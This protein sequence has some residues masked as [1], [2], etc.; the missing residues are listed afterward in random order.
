MANPIRIIHFSDIHFTPRQ[1]FIRS[2]YDAAVQVINT[3][4]H[5]FSVFTGDLTQDGLI[6]EYVLANELRR[7]II[8]PKTY[9]IIG[10]HD[11]RSGGFEVWE[12][13]IG[14]REFHEFSDDVLFIGLD[15]CIPDRDGGRFGREALDYTKK[16][17]MKYGD[18]KIKIVG[19]HHHI[20]PIPKT[21]R[22][23]SNAID[24][25]DMLSVL[26]DHNIDVVFTGHKH[27][28]NVYKVEDTII[29]SAGCV[30]SY[31][32]RS[33]GPRSLN[34]VEII[35]EKEVKTKIMETTGKMMRQEVKTITRSFRM[36]SSDGGK[37]LRLAQISGT[38]FG[39]SYDK[40]DELFT[41]GMELIDNTNPD[42]ILH[43]GNL[44]S[45]GS[46]SDYET[47]VEKFSKYS[48][49]FVFCPGPN[50]LKGY[51]ET[52][53]HKHFDTEN[54]FEKDESC[55][56]ILNTSAPETQV[57][58]VGRTVQNRLERYVYYTRQE[59]LE[60][61][62]TVV[63]H[64]H[65][66]PIPGTRETSA[67]EDA[68]DVLRLLT[69][70][71]VNLVLSGHLGKAFCTRVEKTAFVNCNTFASQTT[72]SFENSFNLIDISTDGAI[73]VSEIHVPSGFRRI[74]GIFPGLLPDKY[75]KSYV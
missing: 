27:H 37:W 10:N 16:I 13:K 65:L 67:L 36:V 34:Y 44:T 40:H 18:A 61:F 48:D 5:D 29:V 33:G 59:N 23:R 1:Q 26:L 24:A 47:A 62:H 31:K 30:S 12:K 14:P 43:C 3:T 74:L 15:S 32:T 19:F 66:I 21:G 8:S 72:S 71:G 64:H 6:E 38:D 69:N 4:P 56:Y 35:P 7:N 51:G 11:S 57:G 22:E 25:G 41:K 52:L 46:S 17:L 75:T 39:T 58:V 49:K 60:K 45:K 73:V 70:T 55:F 20:L 63:M 9:W 68:G 53:L 2:S 50:D 42:L 54:V 28:P